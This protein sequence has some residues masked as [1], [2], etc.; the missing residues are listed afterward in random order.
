[1][2]TNSNMLSTQ[3]VTITDEVQNKGF[4]LIDEMFTANGWHKTKNDINWMCYT[5]TGNETEF[6]DIK[7]DR[8]KI[9][10]SVPMKNSIFQYT[11]SFKDYF[12]ATEYIEN[13]FKYSQEQS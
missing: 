2:N 6:Y 4:I 7:I 11:T 12:T 1:M 13:K 3:Y 10:V 5:K 9:Y 8:N